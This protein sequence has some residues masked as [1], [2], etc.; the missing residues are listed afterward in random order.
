LKD[1]INFITNI[2]QAFRLKLILLMMRI[3]L[4]M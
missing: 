3:M 4:F 2:T 1:W